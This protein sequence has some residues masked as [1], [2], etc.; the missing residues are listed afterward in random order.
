MD[1]AKLGEL[2][3][4]EKAYGERILKH[5]FIIYIDFDAGFWCI[6]IILTI[7]FISSHSSTF[8]FNISL[9]NNMHFVIKNDTCCF[10]MILENTLWRKFAE[11]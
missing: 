3:T 8:T 10:K 1:D 11:K 5:L 4:G 6:C 7:F 9:S 2:C